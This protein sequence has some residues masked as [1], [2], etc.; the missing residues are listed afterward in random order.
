VEEQI[1]PYPIISTYNSVFEL[2]QIQLFDSNTTQNSSV[3]VSRVQ[4]SI[5]I[6]KDSTEN[7]IPIP[8]NYSINTQVDFLSNSNS[9]SSPQVLKTNT[10][11]PR[12]DKVFVLHYNKINDTTNNWMFWILLSS[13]VLFGWCRLLY[14]KQLDLIFKSSINYNFALKSIRN[15]NEFSDR[16]SAILTI[17]FGLNFG[18]FA[19]QTASILGNINM[20]GLKSTGIT[21][22]IG[23]ALVILYGIKGLLLKILGFIF[24]ERDYSQEYVHN[25]HLYNRVL[26]LFM[27]PIIISLAFV[28]RS[29]IS[30]ETLIY[31]GSTV[32]LGMFFLR[33]LRGIQISIRSNI[34][35][36]YMFLY[37]CILEILPIV[38]LVKAGI[39][40]GN[41][42]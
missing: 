6:E 13:L 12:E 28:K 36:L 26:G 31:I 39:I 9:F 14:R 24:Q 20:P 30:H 32:I 18:L 35:I 5:S 37:F 38:V 7:T 1:L 42:L 33:I 40:I 11:K 21:L 41:L 25:M 15:N 16:F 22:I 34:S 29:L 19:F 23:F 2:K 4:N 27:F 10:E 17:I 3:E 8:L